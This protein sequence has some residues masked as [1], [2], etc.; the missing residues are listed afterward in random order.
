MRVAADGVDQVVAADAR[1]VTVAGHDDHVELRAE[2]LDRLGDRQR[3]AVERVDRLVLEVR[4]HPPGAADAGDDHGVRLVE[5]HL[6]E[7][8]GELHHDRADP[9]A[10]APDGR[11]QLDL[12]VL[13][14]GQA[15]PWSSSGMV[16]RPPAGT[17]ATR[18]VGAGGI[19]GSDGPPASTRSTPSRT[20]SMLIRPPSSGTRFTRADGAPARPCRRTGR[21]SPRPRRSRRNDRR[22]R[23]SSSVEHRVD[24]DGAEQREVLAERRRHPRLRSRSDEQVFASRFQPCS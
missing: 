5:P 13:L 20:A 6:V 15:R 16:S 9:A 17:A 24:A 12:E 22:S 3:A 14:V 19:G 11:E 7:D 1:R 23:R 18:S 8:H 10:R 21:R 4:A 2:G